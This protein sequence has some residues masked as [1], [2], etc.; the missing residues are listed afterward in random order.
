MDRDK[1][2][3]SGSLSNEDNKSGQK[4]SRKRS[5][6]PGA[7]AKTNRQTGGSARNQKDESVRGSRQ[8]TTKKQ[9]NSI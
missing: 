1:K 7:P 5:E 3:R 9:S 6:L 4:Q 2:N 8:N